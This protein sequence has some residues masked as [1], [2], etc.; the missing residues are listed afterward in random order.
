MTSS[1][2]RSRG[3]TITLNNYND[4]EYKHLLGMAQLHSEKWILA[5]EIGGGGT[6]HIQGYVYFK[7]PKDFNGVV[8][9]LNNKRIH[10]EKAN[11]NPKQNFA[12]CSKDGDYVSRG[13]D[14][15]N[16]ATF[17]C[18][19]KEIRILP[20]CE[21]MGAEGEEYDECECKGSWLKTI[22]GEYYWKGTHGC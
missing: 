18:L 12:Y 21:E 4:E 5:K 14:E 7:Q 1:R 8:K 3:F 2:I 22:D 16:E 9:L 20:E 10:I 11:G 13:L 15:G 17:P 6:P 19:N